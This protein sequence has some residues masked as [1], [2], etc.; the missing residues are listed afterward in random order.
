MCY[1]TKLRCFAGCL[2]AAMAA[3]GGLGCQDTTPPSNAASEPAPAT[4]SAE[5]TAQPPVQIADT[6]PNEAAP[7]ASQAVEPPAQTSASVALEQTPAAVPTS[8]PEVEVA[9]PVAKPTEAQLARWKQPEFEPLQLLSRHQSQELSFVS[10]VVSSVNGEWLILGGEKLTLWKPLMEKPVAT[11][12]DLRTNAKSESVKSLAIDPTSTWIAAGDA[13]GTLRLWSLSDQK[14][15]GTKKVQNNDLVQ[16]TISDDGKEIATATFGKAISVWQT[17]T[18][19]LLKSFETGSSGRESLLYA[20]PGK[21]AVAGKSLTVWDTATGTLIKT[22][23]E[24]GY[25][26]SVTRSADRS[27]F[28]LAEE[29]R[30]QLLKSSDLSVSAQLNGS[31][32]RNEILRLTA[33]GKFL[34]TVNGSSIRGWNL[35]SGQVV[36]NIDVDQPQVVGL[37]W[38]D[39]RKLLRVVTADGAIRYWGTVATGLAAGLKPLHAPIEIPDGYDVPSTVFELQSM[40]D[41]RT[42]PKP[43]DSNSTSGEMNMLQFESGNAIED[44]KAFYR[45]VFGQ[46]GWQEMPGNAATPD[47]LTFTKKGFKVFISISDSGAGRNSIYMASLGNVDL[48]SLPKIELP[49]FKISYESDS[50]VSYEV[51]GDLLTLETELLKQFSTSGWTPYARLNSSH[52]DEPNSRS[53]EFIRNAMTIRVGIQPKPG[54]ASSYFVQYTAFVAPGHL[55]FPK[56]CDF[57]ECDAARS[58]A[59]VAKTSLSLEDCHA[60]Y[61][62]AMSQV[63]WL[64]SN[65]VKSKEDDFRWLTYFRDQLEVRIQLRRVKEGGSWVVAG[66]YAPQNSWQLSPPKPSA[67]T[68]EPSKGGIQAAD[69]PIFKAADATSVSYDKQ[70]ERIEI[71]LPK[72]SHIEIVDFYAAQLFKLGW[73]EEPNGFRD[74]DYAF[75]TFKK[76]KASVQ[77]RV[78][79][80]SLGTTIG[81]SDDG[82]LWDKNLPEAKKLISY[83]SWLRK[84]SYPASLKLL[85][86]YIQEMRPLL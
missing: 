61:D 23:V 55:P 14:E 78:N 24:D 85:D 15:R 4:K 81:I 60:F 76:D 62:Q 52:G 56:D 71:K 26:T 39:D 72:N 84:N 40:V 66:E 21:L 83:E 6:P 86:Q 48:R 18:L 53:M 7:A 16:L 41:L 2:L 29:N 10:H 45:Y 67:A 9:P 69:I 63:G 64:V 27:L 58:P 25:V 28:A 38:L 46:R 43:P 31:F 33:D 5:P 65:V 32:A 68:D 47:Y 49:G 34:W 80:N 54:E 82:L 35:A 13:E 44:T 59:L 17:T 57:I 1:Q 77:V 3:L 12:W 8:P 51:A 37:D 70:Q 50:N 42:I 19:E 30:L 20:G 74:E 11:L 73:T 75:V 79:S 36:Q 22:L